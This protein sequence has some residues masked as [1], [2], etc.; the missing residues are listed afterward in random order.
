[1]NI[2]EIVMVIISSIGGSAVLFASV[3][4]LVR[5]IINHTLSKDIEKFKINLKSE[6][7]QELL[8]MHSSLQL[9]EFEHQIR[10]S[11][12]HE[13]LAEAAID[14][15]GKLRQVYREV[16]DRVSVLS[17]DRRSNEEIEDAIRIAAKELSDCYYPRR[18]LFPKEIADRIEEFIKILRR[19]LIKHNQLERASNSNNLKWD[20]IMDEIDTMVEDKLPKLFESLETHF[21]KILGVIS[22]LQNMEPMREKS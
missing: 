2:S 11:Q 14:V 5:S 8:R 19:V 21:R 13:R 6:S 15:Y 20:K 7:E 4:W 12:L 9:A 16:D 18:I 17:T 3:A 1:M 10:F 22:P